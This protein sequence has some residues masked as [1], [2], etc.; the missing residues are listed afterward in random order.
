MMKL[1]KSGANGHGPAAPP[2]TAGASVPM[3]EYQELAGRVLKQ[4]AEIERLQSIAGRWLSLATVQQRVIEAL[5]AEIGL[6]SKYVEDHAIAL[7][8]RFQ[9][10]AGN[11]MAQ[12]KR[13]DSLT[14]IANTVEI[15]GKAITLREIADLLDTALGDV[16]ATILESVHHSMSTV[17]SLD[18]VENNL[19]VV[20]HCVGDIDKVTRQTNFLALN[21]AIEAER[22][23]TAGA[24]F[25]VIAGEVRELSK[26]TKALAENIRSQ[27]GSVVVGVRKGH[28]M[29]K[30][31]ATVDMSGNIAAK[32]RLNELINAMH[33][34]DGRVGAII[35]ETARAA[36][37][38]SSNIV[39][40][41]TGMQFQDRTKQRLEHVMDALHVLGDGLVEL[42]RETGAV[43]PDAV[44]D[45]TSQVEWLKSL[46]ARCTLGEVRE[47]FVAS[48]LEGHA[49]SEPEEG[50]EVGA[51][52]TG[53]AELF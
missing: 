35:D 41:V 13:A 34:R 37:D 33:Q 20:E 32:D 14:A 6:A 17:Y 40:I 24:A 28:A 44:A 26:S 42:Q 7:S 43:R 5:R 50:V 4:E 27:I 25:R 51:E 52:Q 18:D 49:P 29:L 53:D 9:T 12:T 8:E 1:F 45:T 31:V 21:A 30:D 11:A 47:R 3:H 38:I 2:A 23:G 36:G 15:D 39:S 16:V 22:A 10:L 19:V 48:L 46:L